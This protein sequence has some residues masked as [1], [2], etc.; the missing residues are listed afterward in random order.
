[1]SLCVK[2]RGMAPLYILEDSLAPVCLGTASQ[3]VIHSM[4]KYLDVSFETLGQPGIWDVIGAEE[5]INFGRVVPRQQRAV[6]SVGNVPR[7]LDSNSRVEL[8]ANTSVPFTIPQH[9]KDREPL[10]VVGSA[11]DH[12]SAL[13]HARIMRAHL[14]RS[15]VILLIPPGGTEPAY[16]ARGGVICLDSCIFERVFARLV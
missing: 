10:V 9:L 4:A 12:A 5:C 3:A 13:I 7:E 15:P 11:D 8:F 1:M 6:I 2:L 16:A 14:P